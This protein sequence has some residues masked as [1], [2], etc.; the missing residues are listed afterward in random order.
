MKNTPIRSAIA[1]RSARL[2]AL[3]VCCVCVL[4]AQPV[5]D[6]QLKQ[7]IIFGRHSVRSPYAPN[8]TIS[9]FAVQPYPTFTAAPPPPSIPLPAYGYLTVNGAALETILGGYYRQWLTKEGLLTGNDAADSAFVSFRANNIERTI[10]TAQS[11]WSGLLPA[12]GPP[13]V[14]YVMPQT[15]IDPLFDPVDAGLARLDQQKAVAAVVGRLGGNPESLAAAYASEYALARSVL[16]G[17]PA[18]QIPAPAA[19]AGT[20]DAT[21]IPITVTTGMPVTIAGMSSVG[22]AID[23]FIMEYADGMPA[24]DVG[25]GRLTADGINQLGR[26]YNLSIDLEFRTPYLGSLLSSNLASH[27]VNS[28]VQA[29]TG[30]PMTGSLGTPSTKAVV[31][32]ASDVNIAGLAGLFHL[33]WLLPGYQQDYCPPGG[34]LVFQ[35]R[36]SQHNGE[37]IVRASYVSQTLDQLRNRSALTLTAP[38]VTAPIFIPGCSTRNATFDCPLANFVTLA[39]QVVDERFVDQ[40]DTNR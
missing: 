13:K 22:A 5:D 25:W 12:A 31:L 38:P 1:R 26:L 3:A 28:M 21:T 27:V 40:K 4:E 37:Y 10:L 11:F 15:T 6:T 19:P 23:P 39:K 24:A 8:S 7:V 14:T 35:L 2:A 34:A 29:A 17:Y 30:N 32:I 33:D 36:Q 9:P 18:S 20:V 16:F